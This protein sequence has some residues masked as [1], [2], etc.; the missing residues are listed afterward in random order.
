MKLY[1]KYQPGLFMPDSAFHPQAA[2]PDTKCLPLA[3]GHFMVV[4]FVTDEFKRVIL[5]EPRELSLS[6]FL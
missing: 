5:P 6:V 1:S 3:G 4:H 2:L